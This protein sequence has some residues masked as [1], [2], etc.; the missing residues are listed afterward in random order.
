MGLFGFGKNDPETIGDRWYKKSLRATDRKL[1]YLRKSAS[2]GSKMGMM[3]LARH[4][5][6]YYADDTAMIR[7]AAALAEK[8]EAAGAEPDNV[9]LGHIYDHLGRKEEAAERCRRGAEQGDGW[10]Q[11]KTAQ[12]YD[13]GGLFEE[14]ADKARIWY[15]KA[16]Q[17]NVAGGLCGL[18]GLYRDGR[19]VEKNEPLS[20][21]L[22]SSAAQLKDLTACGYL[23]WDY[24]H[25]EHGC[26]VDY[27]K[28]ASYAQKGIWKWGGETRCRYVMG[29]L[30]C[31]GLGG[32]PENYAIGW[33]TLREL[34]DDGF[35]PASAAM[36]KCYQH[37]LV[38]E[39]KYYLKAKKIGT[40]EAMKQAA[41][42][43][44]TANL[45]FLQEAA[46]RLAAGETLTD[47]ELKGYVKNFSRSFSELLRLP[48]QKLIHPLLDAA[49]ARG[50]ELLYSGSF[51]SALDLV[52]ETRYANH[53]G[54]QFVQASAYFYLYLQKYDIVWD[55]SKRDESIQYCRKFLDNPEVSRNEDYA[56]ECKDV[57]G[58]LKHLHFIKD[59]NEE[60]IRKSVD[61]QNR[62][63]E[64]KQR[65]EQD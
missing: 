19:G 33:L 43:G 39:D 5:W 48:P 52:E 21:S 44:L 29:V 64:E 59:I 60:A 27:E 9:L 25:G 22:L 26:P 3:G 58:F 37:R 4:Y 65:Q 53:P 38:R 61:R 35:E 62:R 18:G 2:L 36:E 12:N 23:A 6:E 31:E 7:Q 55:S 40:R 50:R 10:C 42:D 16:A 54:C 34:N 32:V 51:R 11:Y 45:F 20:H 17:Q 30:D 15:E 24:L 46:D 8:A 57:E 1:E 14:N 41:A 56:E 28:A 63:F 13:V 47:E 49:A